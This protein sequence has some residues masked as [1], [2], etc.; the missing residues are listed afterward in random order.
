MFRAMTRIAILVLAAASL[1]ASLAASFAGAAAQPRRDVPK[2]ETKR[3]GSFKGWDAYLL[4]GEKGRTLCYLHGQPSKKEPA[5]AKRGEIYLLVTHKP[6]EKIRNEV[7]IFFGYPLKPESKADAQIGAT[8]IAM[9]THA[10]AAWADNPEMDA[11]LVDALKKGKQLVVSGQ[12]A[13]GT[14]TTDTY[15]LAGFGDALKAIDKACP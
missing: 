12:S 13:K 9:F 1:A 2:S 11:S 14:K 8:R 4:N 5:S 3:I 10:E 15:D 6:A 7:S